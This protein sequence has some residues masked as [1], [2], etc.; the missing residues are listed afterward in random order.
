[1]TK[2]E[3]K[4]KGCIVTGSA[5]GLGKSFAKILLHHGA[6]VCV[7]DIDK[8]AGEETYEEFKIAYG[9]KNVCY[10]KCDVTVQKEFAKLFDEAEK[11]FHVECVDIL[12]NNAGINTN[13]GWRKCIEVN[14]MGVMTGCEIALERMRKYPNKGNVVNVGSLAGLLPGGGEFT[15]AYHLTK[16]AVISLTRTLANEFHYHGVSNKAIL[17]AWADTDIMSFSDNMPSYL[18]DSVQK[19]VDA[20]GGL[21]TTDYVAEGFHQLVSGC[22]NGSI[23]MV[24]KNTPYTLIPDNAQSSL[25]QMVIKAKLVGK[26]C[27]KDLITEKDLRY[28]GIF[29]PLIVSMIFCATLCIVFWYVFSNA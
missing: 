9:I 3:V 13:F 6:Q 15:A 10:V 22:D 16:A 17:L 4:N 8:E 1:M 21:M 11:Y 24:L 27:R 12:V 28:F 5:R 25:H 26:V 20:C 23:M 18:R 2:T 29:V 19:S 7:S 14:L